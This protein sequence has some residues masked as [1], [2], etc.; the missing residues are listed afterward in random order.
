MI[1]GGIFALPETGGESIVGVML[2]IVAVHHGIEKM[3]D[4]VEYE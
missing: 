4:A 2:G 1:I 3:E